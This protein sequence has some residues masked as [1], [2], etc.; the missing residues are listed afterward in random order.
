[1]LSLKDALAAVRNA[2][3]AASLIQVDFRAHS[4]KKRKQKGVV[5]RGGADEYGI[6][7]SDIEGLSATSKLTYGNAHHHN[8]ALAIQ[9]KHRGDDEAM[10]LGEMFI[11]IVE[12]FLPLTSGW[13]LRID[14][15]AMLLT[16]SPNIKEEVC[17]STVIGWPM[18][19]DA[20]F[21]NVMSPRHAK[22]I[23]INLNYL[24][25]K[26]A[27]TKVDG[28]GKPSR[29]RQQLLAMQVQTE[30]LSKLQYRCRGKRRQ[31]LLAM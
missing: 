6:L 7:P 11:T 17:H 12:Y 3:Q 2:S 28:N 16:R 8:A 20:D 25:Y 27:Q 22:I 24:H 9:K 19:M 15:L 4:F 13:G 30:V 26:F 29:R 23:I 5:E 14:I 18:R 31:Q 21:F 10:D 1:Y